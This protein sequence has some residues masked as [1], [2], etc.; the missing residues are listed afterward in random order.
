VAGERGFSPSISLPFPSEKGVMGPSS[1]HGFP[2]NAPPFPG[3]LGFWGSLRTKGLG[4]GF[5]GG[6]LILQGVWRGAVQCGRDAC[7]ASFG[8]P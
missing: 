6:I 7:L 5:G 4:G 2:K 3:P 8:K 1:A